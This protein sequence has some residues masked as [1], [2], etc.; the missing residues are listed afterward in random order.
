MT[1]ASTSNKSGPYNGNGSIANFAV[2]FKY[3]ATSEVSVIVTSAAGVQTTKVLDTH[4]TLTPPGDSGTVSFIT[5]PTDHRP[6]SGET[7]TILGTLPVTQATD[8][9]AGGAFSAN[10]IE[11]AFDKLTRL[12]QQIAEKVTRAPKLRQ[13]TATGE[14]TLPEPAASTL[15]RWN[16]AG[17]DLENVA[18]ADIDLGVVSPF[19][20]TLLDDVT[21]AEARTTLGAIGG[22]TGATDNAILRASGTEGATLDNSPVTITD[23]GIMNGA[24]AV[25]INATADVTNRLSVNSAAVLFNHEGAGTQIKVNKNAAGD[26]A[27][28]LFQTGFSGRAEF[29]LT[30]SNDF[31]MKTSPD[32]SAFTTGLS[33]LASTAALRAH[34]NLSP[35]AND[36]AALG[37][38]ALGWADLH[39]ATG[40]TL[41]I[42]NGNWLATHS[43][44]VMTVTTGDLRV[45]NNFTNAASVV[46]VGGAQTLTNKTLTNPALATSYLQASEIATP[47]NPAATVLRVY[48]KADGGTT[49]LATLDSAGTETILGSGGGAAAMPRGHI[50][51]LILSNNG[52]DANND[53]D[54]AEGEARSDD[55]TTDLAL[56]S[57]ITKRLDAGWAVGTN[58]GG[59]D[60]GSE[61]ANTWYYVWLIKRTDTDVVDVLFSASATSPTMPANYTKKRR[62]GAIRN[63][64]S[65]NILAFTQNANDPELFLFT[66]PVAD[67]AVINLGTT[68]TSFTLTVPPS[69][70][71]LLRVT[72]LNVNNNAGGVLLRPLTE[73]DAAPSPS[74]GL[75]SLHR[76]FDGSNDVPSSGHFEIQVN[77]S[78][79]IA[80]RASAVN[81]DLS[82]TTRGWRDGRGRLN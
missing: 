62:I 53:I 17:D 43:S 25:G 8:L 46:T 1:V 11:G 70:T 38:T 74:T 72:L 19:I 67:I 44:A 36:G 80:A 48:A 76:G 52:T 58:Q 4:Y 15:L 9:T 49:K 42:A 6:Q 56:A 33:I 14:I 30:G 57:A 20:A 27:S 40:W 51:G 12:V 41:N 82:A 81:S 75:L 22:S 73:T 34:V 66:T 10:V 45:A 29:G 64:A 61:A 78:S 31:E 7:V 47:S 21:A 39:G 79:Q 13:T 50:F 77:A 54:V 3:T 60:T 35:N 23:A 68:S 55:N 26:T 28:Y 71:A 32:G 65:S 2:G 5:A 18:A 16:S 69:M 59:L 37:T 63:N 24:V